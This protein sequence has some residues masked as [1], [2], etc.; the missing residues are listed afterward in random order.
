MP[1]DKIKAITYNHPDYIPVAVSL[2]PATWMKYRDDLQALV[3]RHPIIFGENNGQARDYDAVSGTYI[4]GEHV[5]IWG[6][7]WSNV[8]QG[9]EAIVT[10]HPLP[11]RESVRTMKPPEKLLGRL[12]HGF[13]FLRLTDLR[14]YEEAMIDFAEDAPELQMLIDIV[15][16]HNMRELDA[17]LPNYKPGSYIYFGDD[18]GMQTSLPISPAKWRKYLKPCYMKMYQKCHDAGL[19]V[20][21]HTD[22][23]ILE[24]IPDLVDCGVN[25]INPQIRANGLEGLARVCKG[26]VCL[27][28]DLDR[29]MFPFCK[30]EDIDPH[31]LEVVKTLGAPEGGLWLFAECAPDVPLENIEAI[32]LAM[33]KY[34][35]YFR[36]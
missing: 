27:N 10:G 36:D 35:G 5:D 25:I 11:T 30:P 13:M 1:D 8:A 14:G 7:T 15:L 22:G 24:I 3:D 32:C 20:Y 26:K 23:H 31:V 19:Y 28:L 18:L 4:E 33:E 9:M 29:Q 16:E 2:L 6:C 12:P 21:M 17:M 34:R